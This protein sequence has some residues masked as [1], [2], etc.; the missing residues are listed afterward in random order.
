[1]QENEIDELFRYFI[2]SDYRDGEYILPD[3]YEELDTII[4]KNKYAKLLDDARYDY[5]M[6]KMTED[7]YN[8]LYM[9]YFNMIC[10]DRKLILERKN[11][12]DSKK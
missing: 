5:I 7:E 11:N 3:E 10:E 6:G 8:E 4:K 12:N 2:L 1:M 9:F